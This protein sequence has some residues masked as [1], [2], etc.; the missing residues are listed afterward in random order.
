MTE[1]A[2]LLKGFL[3]AVA[4]VGAPAPAPPPPGK[5]AAK[6]V[7]DPLITDEYATLIETYG[8]TDQQVVK[9]RALLERKRE[10]L[11][12]WGRSNA[13]KLRQI[14]QALARTTDSRKQQA[15]RDMR[16][17]LTE[18]RDRIE[19]ECLKRAQEIPTTP[20]RVG[21]EVKALKARLEGRLGGLT[22]TAKQSAAIDELCTKIA[23]RVVADRTGK[24]KDRAFEALREKVEQTVLTKEQVAAAAVSWDKRAVEGLVSRLREAL[25]YVTFTEEQM[26]TIR[27]LCAKLVE[28]RSAA[29]SPEDAAAEFAALRENVELGIL[30]ADQRKA[31]RDGVIKAFV[32]D[33]RG[34]INR[35]YK[36]VQFTE[37]QSAAINE[38]CRKGAEQADAAT[39]ADPAGPALEAV[40]PRIDE[41]LTKEQREA[42]RLGV[43]KDF[44]DQLLGR[45]NVEF[46]HAGLNAEQKADVAELCRKLAGRVEPESAG[47]SSG[48]AFDAAKAAIY[49]TVLTK[50]QQKDYT[51]WVGL[52]RPTTGLPKGPVKGDAKKE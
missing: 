29:R 19:A 7:K 16:G 40:R 9:L 8:L 2:W 27:G 42:H 18:R 50:Q 3:V 24:A 44:V 38:M 25:Q 17:Q 45:A 6:E 11:E 1:S 26:A 14:E 34:R 36:Y 43:K 22:L 33:L 46:Q 30:T 52:G 51:L 21:T 28:R 47:R 31:Q 49:E 41:M 20:Q 35:A 10:L 23:E 5:P 32:A 48:P 12:K 4:A 37:Q 15:L 39:L 13:G